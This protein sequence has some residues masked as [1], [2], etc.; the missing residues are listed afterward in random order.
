MN[1]EVR[2]MQ[3]K[4]SFFNRTLFRKN[5]TRFW[6]LWALAS[7]GGALFPLALL[8]EI[9]RDKT[10]SV[11][12]L[13]VT[14][15]YY[16]V[17]AYGV[18]IISLIYAI[19]CAVAVWSYLY[20]ARSAGL[21]HT[22]PIRREGLFV[23]NFLSG[24]AMMLIPYVVTGGLMILI[25]LGCGAFDPVGVLVTV[26]G[27]LGESFFYFATATLTAFCVGNVFALPA[28]Y[29]L[30]HFLAVIL[31]WMVSV[32]SQGFI[33][34]LSGSYSGTVEYLSPTVYLINQV[35]VDRLYEEQF[36]RAEL[37][38]TGYYSNV[39]VD[40]S[41]EKGWLIGVYALVGVVCMVLAY[42][43]YRRRRS[44][45][46]G[47]VVAVGWMKPIFRYGGAALAAVLGGI[48]LYELFWRSYNYSQYYQALPLTVCMAAAGAI[49]Y[50]GASML[51]AKSLKVFRQTWKGMGLVVIG[52]AAICCV[53]HFDVLN[54]TGRV[55]EVSQVESVRLY[56]AGNN[57]TFYPGE[58][59][60]LLQKVRTVHQAI[61]AD[62]Q[63]FMEMENVSVEDRGLRTAYT[64]VRL[65]YELKNGRTVTR[66]YNLRLWEDRLEQPETAEYLLDQLVNSREMRL[67]R[68]HVADSGY[69]A[70]GGYIYL[71][72]RDKGFDLSSR[73]A[74]A[75]L[76]AVSQDA[77][78]GNWGDVDW[79]VSDQ[80]DE[81]AIDLRLTYLYESPGSQETYS[82]YDSVV[83]TLRPEMEHTIRCLKELRLVDEDDLITYRELYPEQYDE[84]YQLYAEKYGITSYEEYV[85]MRNSA[86][87]RI[88]G[89]SESTAVVVTAA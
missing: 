69:Q 59:D 44:E 24:M 67:R 88:E 45:S 13:Q 58:D 63:Y 22:L 60:D 7:L 80:R 2:T 20:N 74:A 53:L 47:D 43:L 33:F 26:L 39:L 75:I 52:C 76:E 85:I 21:M 16:E 42:A 83:I 46:A 17:L 79:F 30:L 5:L 87:F 49:G 78:A 40:V 32:F 38:G 1:W 9:L 19:L 57:Y 50:F 62:A 77:A 71:E 23:T 54:I 64:Y 34:G 82:S 55:P 15:A 35:D 72:S 29:F 14:A 37:T 48:A 73:E 68:I 25:S 12:A 18:P 10:P 3:S 51:L 84:E 28:V 66:R 56:V 6:P 11:E 61:A 65:N 86:S 27:V 31:D 81:Y 41:L 8:L 36:M 89:G 4:R 70:D